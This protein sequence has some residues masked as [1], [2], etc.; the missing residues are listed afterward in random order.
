MSDNRQHHRLINKIK[1][2]VIRWVVPSLMSALFFFLPRKRKTLLVVKT[3]GIGDYILF[4]NYLSFLKRSKK[5]G[6]Y[7]IYLLGNRAS[8][9]L[10]IHLDKEVVDG[11]FWYADGFFL[12][13]DLVRLLFSLQQLR[14]ATIVH[15]SYSRRS[16]T[17]WLIGQVRADQKIAFDGDTINQTAVTK[18]HTDRYYD[19]LVRFDARHLHEFE[20]NKH[21]FEAIT[22]EAC[23][24][25]GP[26]LPKNRFAIVPGQSIVMFAGAS[27]E[28]KKWPSDS[29][30]TLCRR[31][32]KEL[33]LA[34][35]LAEGRYDA[36]EGQAIGR[37]IP[38]GRFS[39]RDGLDM[40]GLCGL[41][42]GAV[43]LVTVDTVAVHVAAA[44][45]VPVVCICK[46]DLYGRFVP[47]PKS[48]TGKVAC[49][50]PEGYLAD[51]NNDD[52]W[53]HLSVH[54][55]KVD[56]VF[57]CVKEKLLNI[58]GARK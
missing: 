10:A 55:I 16:T 11:F 25:T 14:P 41:I 1:F 45:G 5:Y 54:E 21:F 28:S 44:L 50:F 29:F 47:Y 39:S 51:A 38:E 24:F 15:A 48:I 57:Q 9:E 32:S 30:N 49:V 53:S 27:T 17:D 31:I 6:S 26:F 22:A 35:I 56:D 2:V 33:D 19:Q 23:S 18:K 40:I 3:D 34:I 20:R 13:W 46:G 52:R 43:L 37:G 4:R 58:N 7:K 36:A 42:G 8:K 12:K